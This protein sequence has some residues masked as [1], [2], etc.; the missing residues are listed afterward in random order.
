MVVRKAMQM[1]EKMNIP[2]LGVV[3]NMSYLIL[4]D[5]GKRI[6][7]FGP[8]RADEMAKAAGAPLLGQIPL[9]PELA[10]LCDEGHIERYS[11]DAFDKFAETVVRVLTG[12][13]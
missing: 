9:D 13:Q 10:R 8:S 7:V 5:S 11:S 3:E 6:E 1:T 4:P 2:I 12:G